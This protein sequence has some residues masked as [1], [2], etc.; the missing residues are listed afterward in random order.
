MRKSISMLLSCFFGAAAV[1]VATASFAEGGSEGGNA[2][3]G[4]VIF[5]QGKG[6]AAPCMSCHGDN[7]Q[8]DDGMGTPRLANQGE[9][10]II[11]QLAEFAGDKR[12]PTGLG[13]VMNGFAKALSDQDRRDVAAY[14][15]SI[16]AKPQL[17]DLQALKES[18]QQIGEAYLGKVLVDYGV[19][20]KVPACKSCHQYNGRG[21]FPMFPMIGQQRY[22]YLVNQLHNWRANA[23]DIANG[24]Y[25]R[26]N[27]PVVGGAGMM[28][29]VAKDLTD[30][31]ILNVAAFLASA[32]ATTVGNSRVPE[33]K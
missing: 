32:P 29:V 9:A 5:T 22:V 26:T 4:K 1:L 12:V 27:D 3:N 11:K 31:D 28:R 24:A 33:Q 15:S 2:A 7:G 18:G 20:D 19:K 6:D 30:A 25:A 13:A 8:G 14:L 23:A 16:D 21:A 17:S 10:Y